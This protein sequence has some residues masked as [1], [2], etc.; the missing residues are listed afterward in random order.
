MLQRLLV[1]AAAAV[2]SSCTLTLERELPKGEVRGTVE[3]ERSGDGQR[4]GLGGVRARITGTP[5]VSKSDDKG[6]FVLRSLP[7]G[8]HTIH[9]QQDADN[10]GTLERQLRLTNVVLE[11]LPPGTDP[12]RRNGRDLGRL[13][14]EPAGSITG[15]IE[16]GGIAAAGVG[17]A[18]RGIPGLT[19]RTTDDGTYRFPF[20]AP[21]SY[22]L[23]LI[24]DA[25]ETKASADLGTAQVTARLETKLDG[26]L[27]PTAQPKG[28]LA[29]RLVRDDRDPTFAATPFSTFELM[30][31][32]SD[33]GQQR[34]TL[35]EDGTYV[36]PELRVG[37]YTLEVT[38][39][40]GVVP[41]KMGHVAVFEGAT[42]PDIYVFPADPVLGPDTDGD[43]IPDETDP[44]DDNDEVLDDVDGYQGACAKDPDG[45]TDTDR[46][47][48]C[49]TVDL[50]SDNDGIV[51]ALDNCLDAKNGTQ[52]DSDNDGIGDN[53]DNCV[54]VPNPDQARS[55]GSERGDACRP[56]GCV[57]APHTSES[58]GPDASCSEDGG[59]WDCRCNDVALVWEAGTCIPRRAPTCGDD[60]VG[61]CGANAT[62]ESS[63][64][65][66]CNATHAI[67]MEPTLDGDHCRTCESG[68]AGANCATCATGWQD[69]DGDGVCAPDCTTAA[70]ACLHGTCS[71]AS[72]AAVC[73]CETGYEDTLCGACADG[74]QDNN[75]D[76]VCAPTCATSAIQCGTHGSC[77]DL[78]GTAR[79]DCADGWD[80]SSCGFC[81]DGLQ[82]NDGNDSCLPTCETANL[83]CGHGVCDDGTGTAFCAC[84]A[85][86]T[87][88]GCNA[89]ENG[90]QNNDGN[91]TCLPTCATLNISCGHGACDDGSGTA[92]CACNPGWTGP[93]CDACEP[94]LQNNDGNDTCLP[95]CET[96]HLSCGHGLCND[97]SGTAACACD[98]GWAAP[99]CN[100]C[101][102]GLQDKNDDGTCLPTCATANL[103]C[104]HG[105]CS[106][107]NGT[108]HCACDDGWSEALCDACA[109][110][111]QN[112][113]GDA[114]CLPT[115]A[116]AN[117]SCGN[118]ACSDDSGT[119]ACAC[120]P[121]WTGPGCDACE[122]GLQDENGD[123]TCL[124]T[125]DA[126]A[127]ACVHGACSDDDGTAH[128]ACDS[129]WSET[130]CDACAA[131]LQ[132]ND[133]DATCLP[134]CA[135][136]GLT[137]GHGTCAD[138]D[139]TADCACNSGWTGAA[140]DVDIDECATNTHDC[141]TN[142]TCTDTDGSFSCACVTGYAGAGTT[143]TCSDVDAC[144]ANPCAPGDTCEDLPAP[145]PNTSAGR[146]CIA[147]ICLVDAGI[148]SCSTAGSG[149]CLAHRWSFDEASGDALDGAGSTTGE[150]LGSVTRG[151]GVDVG[152]RALVFPGDNASV[153]SLDA[154][155]AG[156]G[157]NDFS[158][159]FWVKTSAPA[160][161]AEFA[162]NRVSASHGNFI[163]LRQN[164]DG[165]FSAEIDQD[166]G[167]TNYAAGLTQASASTNTWRHLAIVRQGATLR[168]YLDGTEVDS[169]VAAGPTSINAG[170]DFV[171]GGSQL[172]LNAFA[173]A[174]D[175]LR[176][177]EGALSAGNVATLA[178]GTCPLTIVAGAGGA[179]QWSNGTFATSC[180]QYLS[181][182]SGRIYAGSTGSG[183]YTIAPT[184]TPFPAYCD[185][186]FDG[187]GWTLV[188]ATGVGGTWS[189][190]NG[191]PA[192]LVPGFVPTGVLTTLA[193]GATQVHIRSNGQAATRSATSIPNT[194]PI[195]NLRNGMS[196]SEGLEFQDP[197][198]YWT[199]T[200]VNRLNRSCGWDAPGAWPNTYWACGYPGLHLQPG[201]PG[202]SR[203]V[204]EEA[205][206]ALE[207][208]VR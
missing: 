73:V 60:P 43:G 112:N 179:R 71:D 55:P 200:M 24:E 92:A 204:W 35:G 32:D 175:D 164:P 177:Y 39:T 144:V 121:G 3:G 74:Y 42:V 57:D 174:L 160:G 79:C 46:D 163:S 75:V 58:C 96:A 80:G 2:I 195:V 105:V 5:F 12:D 72:G 94:G 36:L 88:A 37:F 50:D 176:I 16:R 187:G 196:A 45:S 205:D 86:W 65:C 49:D 141:D 167:G 136:A 146:T 123:G 51:D 173:G 14:L 208:Y 201:P 128:C 100:T 95:T 161:A 148:R 61:I 48:L 87:G 207:T 56:R 206:E 145:A 117:L 162:G 67:W 107:D 33:G 63:V 153:L 199:G 90:L 7:S 44:D 168:I 143:G 114:T 191:S 11:P 27:P 81:A 189:Y 119:A 193:N 22:A 185:M 131:G 83:S 78:S 202:V 139:G 126:A 109:D 113:D 142:A 19:A 64:T 110:G 154:A 23:V 152:G 13:L 186:T 98:A 8:T 165:Q 137:C 53:C 180:K 68:Y 84:D 9:L 151:A 138:G 54:T 91:D 140:C 190:S 108:A 115:C 134:T 20:M 129:G 181:P 133:G 171:F 155:T 192:P 29:G 76:S 169:D 124:P 66:R 203:W 77:S 183:T 99:G 70:P 62:C 102:S 158:L 101:E 172:G 59:A 118:G 184:G 150:I 40:G 132:N 52:T 6:R 41:Y 157:T 21:G 166:G 38:T 127:L 97:D 197:F 82:N 147:P 25:G 198:A 130:L 194:T 28:S 170:A 34:I 103:A 26:V 10:D 4:V 30:L 93:A 188:L 125:C 120:N 31:H 89:C 135:T 182:P 47:G 156:F 18:I 111:F 159:T 85:G 69:N 106:D 122:N 17:V 116:T 104:A 178:E 15:R 149:P 1:L